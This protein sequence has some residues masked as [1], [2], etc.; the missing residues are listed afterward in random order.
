MNAHAAGQHWWHGAT[1]Y[2]VYVRSWR[3]SDG[4]GYGD[5]RGVISGLD[6]LALAGGGRRLAVADDALPRS[7]LGL[8][9]LGLPGR[10]SR[11]RHHGRPR[12]AGRAGGRAGHA[13][14]AGPGA[15]PHQQRPP[16]V[17]GRPV[18]P[19]GGAPQLLHLG[20]PGARRRAP[21]Q[22]AERDR[23]ARVDVRRRQRPVLPAQLPAQPAGPELAG[24]GRPRGV[25]RDPAVL[26]RP[27]DRRVPHRRRARPVQ[28]RRSARRPAGGPGPHGRPVRPGP[29]VQ[30]QPPGVARGVPG[31]AGDRR[32]L[33]PA[34][35]AARRDLGERPGQDGRLSRPRRRAPADV[36]L[37]GHLRR[38]HRR[39]AV[40]RGGRDPR[41]PARRGVPGVDGVQSRHQPVPDPLVRRGRGQSPAGAAGAGDTAGRIRSVLRGRDRDDRREHP[42]RGQPGR[43]QRRCRG[44]DGARPVPDAHAVGR[45]PDGGLHRPRRPALA[46]HR[47]AR[48][49]QRGPPAGRPRLDAPVL[50]GAARAAPRRVRRHDRRLHAAARPARGLGVPG[51]RPGGRGQLRRRARLPGRA[52]GPAA[53]VHQPGRRRAGAGRAGRRLGPWEGVIVRDGGAVT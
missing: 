47:R 24:A 26:V 41:R 36:Q 5:L 16:L 15:Q 8:R 9:R 19:G 4:D 10:P 3:D 7:R 30:R 13:G 22:L 17:R 42:G 12:R 52:D 25:R 11:A 46:A 50:P 39:G 51:G 27:G 38:L 2:Q 48:R 6:Y 20:R 28:G 31:L 21:E 43:D 18:G 35:A 44:P 40:R 1:L 29:G 23:R 53:A 33:L 45:L 32:D 14:A 49:A 37:P 34:P